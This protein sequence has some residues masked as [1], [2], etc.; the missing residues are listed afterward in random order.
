MH[1]RSIF[2]ILFDFRINENYTPVSN[3]SRAAKY[4]SLEK[5]YN[6]TALRNLTTFPYRMPK[7]GIRAS[8]VVYLLLNGEHFEYYCR[9]ING[10]KVHLHA[11][12]ELPDM[13]KDIFRIPIDQNILVSVKPNMMTTSGELRRLSPKYRQ[14][15]FDSE[16]QLKF[17]KVYTQR[18]CEL[19]CISN[20][21]QQRC[22]CTKFCLPSMRN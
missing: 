6:N 7:A 19:E 16:R 2:N 1:L 5:G 17:F 3:N 15:Y 4:W 11:P 9:L 21:T 10:F 14:C 22:G 13:N 8:L 12:T 18:N 20:F